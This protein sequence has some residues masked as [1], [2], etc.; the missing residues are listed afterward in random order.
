MS[1]SSSSPELFQ[2]WQGLVPGLSA[3]QAQVLEDLVDEIIRWNR[4]IRLTS[5]A[6][7]EAL[8]LRLVDDSLLL[9]PH[10]KGQSLIDVGTGPG[11]P[12]LP[13]AIALPQLQVASIEPIGK[14]VAFTRAFLSRHPQ[15]TL[16]PHQGRVEA[17]SPGPWGRA[18]TVLSRAFTAAEHWIPLGA[19]LLNPKGRL[20]VT[21]GQLPSESDLKALNQLAS[22][23]GLIFEGSWSGSLGGVSRAVLK[24]GGEGVAGG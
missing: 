12:A 17:G 24:Y 19:Q 6:S 7:R 15:L 1:P 8:M 14:K 11:I 9:A 2:R 21:L 18:D 13:L 3:E 10:L 23:Q 20:L 16:R 22:Q 4:K 5:P